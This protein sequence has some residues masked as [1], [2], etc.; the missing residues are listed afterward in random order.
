MILIIDILVLLAVLLQLLL[1]HYYYFDH[2]YSIAL[3]KIL[4]Q[5]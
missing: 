1:Q 4:L 2:I 5:H 3:N